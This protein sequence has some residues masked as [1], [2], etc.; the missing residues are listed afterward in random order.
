MKPFFIL[1]AGIGASLWTPEVDAQQFSITGHVVAGGGGTSQ[2]SGFSITGTIGQAE[3]APLLQSGRWA[4]TPG[5]WGAYAVLPTPG[6]P[7]LRIR[8]DEF[9]P[10]LVKVSFIGDSEDWILQVTT[11]LRSSTGEILWEDDEPGN[12]VEIDG[13]LV[14]NFHIPSWGPR[15][16]FR[17]RHR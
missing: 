17:L 8:V 5:F 4:V 13:E 9:D 10:T 12:L 14:R 6:A 15:V 16:F 11:D 7:R 3:A 2:G 1:L